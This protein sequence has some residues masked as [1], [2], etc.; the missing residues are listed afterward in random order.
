MP[1]LGLCCIVKDETPFLE[2]WIVFH[3]LMG[4]EAFILYDN[5]SAVPVRDTLAHLASEYK[6]TVI[7]A[8]G[9]GKQIPCYD[10]CLSTFGKQF[11]W[12]GFLDMD[13]FAVPLR[14]GDLR[15][16][17]SNYE[18]EAGLG[19]H[20]TLFGSSGHKTRPEGLQIENYTLA[21]P[22]AEPASWHVKLF[23]RPF[24]IREFINP[25]TAACHEGRIVNTGYA[26]IRGP[27]SIPPVRDVCQINHYY[28][29]SSQ[30][31]Y[32]KLQRGMADSRREHRIPRRINP[33]RGKVEDR[34]AARYAPQVR[35]LLEQPE[36][37]RTLFRPR[38]PES[39]E[40]TAAAFT[41][42]LRHNRPGEALILL[43][44]AR[45]RFPGHPLIELLTR[46]SAELAASF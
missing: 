39:P 17:L 18:A 27:L 5:D 45:R 42:L 25:H 4:V 2:E 23:V 37:A 6:V 38:V 21:I 29:R 3:A 46:E 34:S 12:L 26:P 32:Q 43:A 35:Q 31:F 30:D 36:L 20:W 9:R 40:Q 14:H 19:A 15:L 13:E 8:P 16:M 11:A 10:H 33:P 24:R 22:D 7:E 1:Y 41:D 28:Y 44:K